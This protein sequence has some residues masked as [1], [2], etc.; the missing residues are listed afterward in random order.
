[1][2]V[3]EVDGRRYVPEGSTV[4]T[5]GVGVTTHNRREVFD[6]CTAEI[7]HFTPE[8]K[9]VVVDDSSDVPL[10]GADHRFETQAGIARA[11]NKCLELLADCE[12]I[13]LF[14][15]DCHPKQEGWWKPYVESPEPHLM[16]VFG[17][18]AH[19]K[20]IGD[21]TC[22]YSDSRHVAWAHARGMMLY[23][24]RSVLDVVGGLDPG[25]GLWGWE[26]A[27]WSNRIHA[28]GL[29]AWRYA[30]VV[31]GEDLIYSL[32]EHEGIE[33][34]VPKA[35]RDE[36]FVVNAERLAGQKDRPLYREWRE[37][38]D[39]VL[40]CLFSGKIDAQRGRRT[41]PKVAALTPLI[42]SV[43]ARNLVILHNELGRDGEDGSLT[44]VET[45]APASPYRERWLRP[46]LW[47]RDHPDVH[48]VWIVDATDVEMLH[49]PFPHMESGRLYL[50]TEPKTIA[51]EWLAR[52][53]PDKATL[54]LVESQPSRQLLNCGTVGGDRETV[55]A[56]LHDIVKAWGDNSIAQFLGEDVDLGTTEMGVINVLGWTKWADRLE[57]GPQV[58]TVFKRDERNDFSWWKHK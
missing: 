38:A 56:F 13:F 30:D 25:F 3:V 10:E 28:A 15:D 26:H 37:Q 34:S 23:V 20:K 47:L 54:A 41:Q 32:D 42:K 22:I 31:G 6:R 58:N 45:E 27:D 8:A 1:M 35:V 55:L 7:R 53:H 19:G 50:G 33:R 16:R 5:I 43:G 29:T 44:W 48:N 14:D 36:H 2:A 52:N 18:L 51:D 57:I 9:I 4:P 39:V 21:N 49:D 40:T 24:H 17:D 11:K 46:W 12:H